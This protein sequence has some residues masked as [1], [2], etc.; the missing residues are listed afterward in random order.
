L[1]PLYDLMCADVWDG[2]S[3]NLAQ[4]I[5]GGRRGDQLT[6]KNWLRLAED[7]G[8]APRATLARVSTMI[9]RVE[10]EAADAADE[11]RGMPAGDHPM[12]AAFGDAI[13]R[14]CRRVRSNLGILD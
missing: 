4:D 3:Q 7:A 14:R 10:R 13:L 2:I 1:A 12:L 6:G 8:T 11:V 5:G 9:D